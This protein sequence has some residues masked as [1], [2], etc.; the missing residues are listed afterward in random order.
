[1]FSKNK[2]NFICFELLFYPTKIM[3]C[4]RLLYTPDFSLEIIACLK[5]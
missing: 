5:F 1:M 3:I 2:F 4:L